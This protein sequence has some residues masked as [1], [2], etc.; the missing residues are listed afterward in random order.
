MGINLYT[1]ITKTGSYIPL[2][3]IPNKDFL[4]SEFYGS[5]KIKFDKS[6]SEIIKKF[7]K[8]T[9]IRERRYA[10]EDECASDMGYK[11]AKKCFD[12]S[13]LNPE[14]LDYIIFAQNFG[15][16]NVKNKGVNQVPNLAIRVKEKLE[17]KNRKTECYDILFGCPG[18]VQALIVANRFFK[19]G[20]GKN[21]LLIG[22]ETLSKVSDS[23]D[24][25]SMIYSDG[26]G[27]S[28]VEFVKSENPVG[29]LS[30]AVDCG[31]S[32]CSNVMKM[33]KSYGPINDERLF[34]KMD[35]HNVFKYAIEKV[36]K[37]IEESIDKSG[38][39]LKDI[40]KI[41]IHQANE[42]MDESIVK[43]LFNLYGLNPS[44]GEIKEIMPM[45]IS[46]LGN[47]SVAT[48]PTL[49]DLLVNKKI[50]NHKIKSGDNLV[51]ASVG[52]GGPNINSVV[53]RIP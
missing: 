29:V 37:V 5:E 50:N 4:K 25:D 18:W 27:A 34:F 51:L 15:D 8:I 24:R 48:I 44:K 45:T 9:G 49:L 52:A 30:Y 7:E 28:L 12:S 21:A 17:I 35:G 33:G 13:S 36:P 3:T 19:S 10:G 31:D 41:L 42:R 46:W 11:A 1:I 20:E 53:Y 39:V 47:S 38:L 16:V 40:K 23:Y 14:K 6:N 2:K 32:S 26:A 43:R 22:A